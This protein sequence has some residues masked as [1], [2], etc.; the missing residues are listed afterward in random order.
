MKLRHP[1]AEEAVFNPE[2]ED[3]P[4]TYLL[5]SLHTPT[6]TFSRY[7]LG[8]SSGSD[9]TASFIAKSTPVLLSIKVK[10]K[11]RTSHAADSRAAVLGVFCF[12]C[13]PCKVASAFLDHVWEQQGQSLL[14][15]CCATHTFP[16]WSPTTLAAARRRRPLEKPCVP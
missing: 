16:N 1:R 13:V 6:I 2:R 5:H 15:Y 7:G 4:D 9:R 8:F 3:S 10:H 14:P 12:F 11:R